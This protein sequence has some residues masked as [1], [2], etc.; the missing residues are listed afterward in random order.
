MFHMTTHHTPARLSQEDRNRLDEISIFNDE[1]AS[2]AIRRAIRTEYALL[3][4]CKESALAPERVAAE[5]YDA[6]EATYQTRVA[7]L[8]E[9]RRMLLG[10]RESAV[11]L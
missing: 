6:Y 11:A 9:R 8:N 5:F 2:D 10:D 4:A 1:T 3:Q 7:E